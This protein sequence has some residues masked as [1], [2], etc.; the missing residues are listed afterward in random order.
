MI[1]DQDMAIRQADLRVRIAATSR[2]FSPEIGGGG[3]PF[4]SRYWPD[5]SFALATDD[6][7]CGMPTAAGWCVGAYLTDDTSLPL[8]STYST[9]HSA[10]FEEA[11]D[12]AFAA[13]D[14]ASGLAAS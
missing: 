3:C 8:I 2:G 11:I 10:S 4:L 6:S 7:G 12:L 1:D 13:L 14:A 5:G 9:H